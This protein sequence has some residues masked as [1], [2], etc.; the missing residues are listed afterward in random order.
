[1]L[2]P[3]DLV[4]C[5]GTLLHAGLRELAEAARA[6]GFA[7]VSPWPVQVERTR[8][9]GL[10]DG[11]LRALLAGAGLVVDALDPLLT[12]LPGESLPPG[13]WTTEAQLLGL[14]ERLGARSINLAQGFGARLDLDRAAEALAGVCDRARERGLLVTL[15][16]LPWSGIPDARTALAVVERAGRANAAVM[17]DVWHVFRGASDA[18]QLRALPGARIGGIQL[19]DA[20]A[21][22]APDLVAET[23]QARLLPGDGDAPLAEWLRILAAAGSRAPIGVEV[24]SQELAALPPVEVGRRCGAAARAVLARSRSP[25]G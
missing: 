20:P 11:E 24:F 13:D 21:A 14:A 19:S 23:M 3:D 25:R 5:G 12:W 15:E 22:A 4:L 7:A 6:G 16:F 9:E 8:A 10:G 2:G 17:V 1:V 18:A